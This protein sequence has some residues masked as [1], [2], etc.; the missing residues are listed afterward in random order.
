MAPKKT[1][2]GSAKGT[3]AAKQGGKKRTHPER[4]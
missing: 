4:K 1:T 3:P 2:T